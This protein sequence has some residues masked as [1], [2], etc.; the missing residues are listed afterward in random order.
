MST[1]YRLTLCRSG[2]AFLLLL[3]Q[4]FFSPALADSASVLPS[5]TNTGARVKVWLEGSDEIVVSQQVKLVIEVSTP[6]WFTGGTRIGPL[7][8]QDVV[9]LRR[10][11]FATNST[12]RIGRQTW[13]VQQWSLSLYPQRAGD[14]SVPSID[15]E[16]SIANEE[17]E[18]LRGVLAT[19]AVQFVTNT[20]NQVAQLISQFELDDSQWLATNKFDLQESY[21][22]ATE[23]LEVGSAVTRVVTVK[24]ENVAAMMLPAAQFSASEGLAIYPSAPKVVDK[25]NRGVYLSERIDSV[26]YVLEQAGSYTLPALEYYWWDLSAQSLRKAVLPEKTISTLLPAETVVQQDK[27]SS[28][29]EEPVVSSDQLLRSVIVGVLI[30]CLFIFILWNFRKTPRSRAHESLTK[31]LSRLEK[32]YADDCRSRRYT[33]AGSVFHQWFVYY[34]QTLS[35]DEQASSVR[36]WLKNIG[37]THEAVLFEKLMA[38]AHSA[39]AVV[40]FMDGVDELPIKIKNLVNKTKQSSHNGQ[41]AFHLN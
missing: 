10:E 38:A 30:I 40:D 3:L 36:L 5:L 19:Q 39:V 15:L 21:S 24:S 18:S 20:P 11:K 27:K 2:I 12:R 31:Q 9:I 23:G 32:Q 17:G 33:Q 8:I 7:E 4:V 6:R 35:V 14:F 26:S 1:K 16:L 41:L 13:S 22:G 25:V 34:R 37:S 29:Q 28:M